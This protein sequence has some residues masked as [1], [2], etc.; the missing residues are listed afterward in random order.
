MSFF[1]Q[2]PK[3]PLS[4]QNLAYT[5]P[6]EIAKIRKGY[7]TAAEEATEARGKASAL[8]TGAAI[9]VGSVWLA[10]A[11]IST[12]HLVAASAVGAS[13]AVPALAPA[14]LG[15]MIACIFVMRQKGLNKELL[16]NLYFI[17][18][19]VERM[20]RLHNIIKEI[21]KEK[22]INLN[23]AS[24]SLVMVALQN[25][26]LQ[27]ADEK[28]KKDIENLELYLQEG[29][30]DDARKI[31]AVAEDD[32]TKAIIGSLEEE[33]PQAGGGWFQKGWSKRWLSPDETL[34]QIIRDI[35]IAN[36][37]F[38]IML[39]E[40]DIFMRFKTD[41]T[42]DNWKESKAMKE[43]LRANFQLGT[44]TAVNKSTEPDYDIFYN[45]L[46]LKQ[47]TEGVTDALNVKTAEA[48]TA[49]VGGRKTLKQRHK[50]VGN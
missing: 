10:T 46:E 9:G 7:A 34:R 20:S 42:T 28:T 32:V 47:A 35:T 13:V 23:T 6:D 5:S 4:S 33:N 30:I 39:G 3:K 19:E 41:V 21:S 26:I 11:G 29:R 16:S 17:N 38:S 8:G 22:K 18:M 50:S 44:T 43:L 1:G 15:V 45:I 25:K 49:P 12:A 37:W 24:I 48:K 31:T 27:F 14:T 40:F 36:V 2:K